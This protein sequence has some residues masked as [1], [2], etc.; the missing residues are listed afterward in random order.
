[1][2]ITVAG[3]GYVG[4]SNAILLAQNNEVIAYDIV[5]EKVDLVNNKISPIVDREIQDYLS[6][7]KL[8]LSCTTNFETAVLNADYIIIATPT[9]YD[10]VNHFLTHQLLRMP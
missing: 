7:K 2:K 9:N 4:L 5:Q 10:D 8:N 3:I 1:M 6:N